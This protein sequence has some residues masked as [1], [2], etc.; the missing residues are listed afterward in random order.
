MIELRTLSFYANI[1]GFVLGLPTL[2]ATYY[3]SFKARREAKQARKEALHSLHCLEF[4]SAN[5]A[6]INLVP[7]ETLH[8]CP[9][10]ETSSFCRAAACTP[11]R[12]KPAP[13]SSNRSNTST[14][15]GKRREAVRGKRASP[16]PWRR[17]RQSIRHWWFES[18][19][20]TASPSG[21]TRSCREA[22][23]PPIHS[24][25]ACAGRCGSA[26]AVAV[27]ATWCSQTPASGKAGCSM[28][29]IGDKS[30]HLRKTP[31]RRC[32]FALQLELRCGWVRDR[33]PRRRVRLTRPSLSDRKQPTG[34]FCYL[35]VHR[36]PCRIVPRVTAQP[37]TS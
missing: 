28:T 35:P 31:G 24:R 23:R 6:C 2:L 21:S 16:R 22:S 20:V 19:R 7:L 27:A 32:T 5:G 15:V 12:I 13:T 36:T 17:Y 14:P 34:D 37:S 9:S 8:S 10:R 25:S 3:E 18:F 1:A 29:R 4:V 26:P 33:P 11:M 30:F